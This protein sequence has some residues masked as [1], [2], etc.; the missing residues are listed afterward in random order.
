VCAY[1]LLVRRDAAAMNV[2]SELQ[3]LRRSVTDT[4]AKYDLLHQVKCHFIY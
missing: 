2:D 4:H 3:Q 1:G